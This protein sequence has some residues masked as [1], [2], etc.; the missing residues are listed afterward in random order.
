MKLL[1][2]NGSV[3]ENRATP[4]VEKWVERHAK[5][6][7]ED[8]DTEVVDIKELSLPMFD[9]SISPL[10]NPERNPTG[11]VK[12][13]LDALNAADGYIFIT[14][15][16]NH[17]V[18]SGLKNAIDHIDRQIMK[19]PFMV[20]GHGGVG[21]ARATEQLKLMLNANIGAVPIPVTVPIIGFIGYEDSISTEGEAKTEA[22]RKL[23]GTLKQG[24]E[25]LKWYMEAL[26]AAKENDNENR[27]RVEAEAKRRAVPSTA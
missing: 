24:L 21:G 13:W 18:P 17:S 7:L 2:I 1:V 15:E 11:K 27:I 6:L 9:E 8:I 4:R 19:K 26:N 25:L 22:I 23:E 20:V 14:P 12:Q 3:R 10:M 16:Y 5:A